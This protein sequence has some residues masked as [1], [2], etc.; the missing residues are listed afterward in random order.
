[1]LQGKLAE[2]FLD[3]LIALIAGVSRALVEFLGLENM[4]AII[5]S[6]VSAAECIGIPDFAGAL[7]NSKGL[8]GFA[9]SRNLRISGRFRVITLTDESRY[10]HLIFIFF[11]F[12]LHVYN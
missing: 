10:I 6:S 5:C 11:S 1:M 12:A 8:S 7:N 2:R 4:L 3:I 9:K